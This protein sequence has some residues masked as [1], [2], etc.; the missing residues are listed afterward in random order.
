MIVGDR[1][2]NEM[3]L[4]WMFFQDKTPLT[5]VLSRLNSS[6]VQASR[7]RDSW[8]IC[9]RKDDTLDGYAI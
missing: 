8:Q 1:G 4:N 3:A 2:F 7:G 9:M 5:S 6:L